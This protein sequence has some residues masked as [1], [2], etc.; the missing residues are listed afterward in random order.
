MFSGKAGV[1]KLDLKRLM[2]AFVK[3]RPCLEAAALARVLSAA[4]AENLV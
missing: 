4:T 2:A 1:E 3:M